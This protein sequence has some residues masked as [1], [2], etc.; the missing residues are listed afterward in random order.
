[1][2]TDDQVTSEEAWDFWSEEP[3]GRRQ[4]LVG[5]DLGQAQDY[6]ALVVVR[7]TRLLD[8]VHLFLC[9]HIT[10]FPLGTSYTKIVDD[11]V[12]LVTRPELLTDAETM[13]GR[14]YKATPTLVIDQTGVGRAVV[15]MFERALEPWRGTYP[16]VEPVTIHGGRNSGRSEDGRGWSASKLDLVASAQAALSEGRLKIVPSLDH[17]DLLRRELQDYRVRLSPTGH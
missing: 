9:N 8:V 15:D 4:I 11:V 3:Q 14:K 16:N 1:M 5:L 6:T 10:R 12:K 7:H 2:T 13:Y 17:A